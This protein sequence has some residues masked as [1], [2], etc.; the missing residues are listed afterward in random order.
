[1]AYEMIKLTHEDTT[2]VITLDNPKRR[3]ALSL[4]LMD[5]I[6]DAVRAVDADQGVRAIVLT[7]GD[8][9]FSAGADLNEA[10]A[11]TTAS[12]RIG[13][14][15]RFHK[16][17]EVLETSA[18]PIIAA[19]EGFCITGGF[20]LV[21]ACDIRVGAAGST[22][23]ITSS[24]IGTVAGFGGTQRLPRL[25]GPGNALEILFSAEPI[26]ADHALRIGVLNKLTPAGGALQEALRMGAIYAKRAPLS[27]AFSKRAVYRGL[28]MDL[29]SAIELETFL[30]TTVYGTEDRKEGIS[31]FLDK[32]DAKFSGQ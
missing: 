17:A 29:A 24:R 25:V 15:G 10:L 13:F 23:A 22:Y 19:I 3:N 2:L 31:A 28:Q 8:K 21:L 20:E 14:F 27:L 9:F 26:D 6:I 18:Q 4:R 32:R 7:G 12:D 30:V 16:L 1:M 5:E 11:I